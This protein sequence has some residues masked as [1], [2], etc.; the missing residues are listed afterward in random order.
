MP[1]GFMSMGRPPL[2]TLKDV[3]KRANVAIQ[4]ASKCLNSDP[5]VRSYLRE[6]VL[7]AA[8]D[9]GYRINPLAR[10]MVTGTTNLVTM[11]FFEL[12]NPLYGRLADLLT[13]ELSA[14]GMTAVLC[15]RSDQVVAFNM[16][17]RAA[18]SILISPTADDANR[19]AASLPVVS[20]DCTQWE[21]QVAPDV[22]LDLTA[23]Y[24]ELT[25]RALA[26]GRR[27]FAF[28]AWPDAFD[29]RTKFTTVRTVLRQA[30]LDAIDLPAPCLTSPEVMA[31][32]LSENPGLID[33]IFC[34]NDIDAAK[35]LTAI[36]ERG[37]RVPDDILLIGCDGSIPLPGV[38]TA[39]IDVLD[40]SKRLIELL[41]RQI[42]GDRSKESILLS[43]HLRTPGF[44]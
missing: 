23:A 8:Q 3:A 2:V 12:E 42:G 14:L 41:L 32:W 13:R 19:I 15:E 17:F 38:W 25:R 6:R 34:R 44:R 30:G 22:N 11:S 1:L 26:I 28:Y 43:L 36:A 37:I 4:T 18:G 24:S 7:A 35:A 39:V 9:L 31:Q 21:L 10:A 5:S 20:F 40:A 27:R 29:H 33:A 16:G